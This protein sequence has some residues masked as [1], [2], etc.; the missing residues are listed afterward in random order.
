MSNGRV[1]GPDGTCV[2]ISRPHHPPPP[3]DSNQPPKQQQARG[4]AVADSVAK[5]GKKGRNNPSERAAT[6]SNA[7]NII[8]RVNLRDLTLTKWNLMQLSTAY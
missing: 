4:E 7:V 5:K 8:R 3:Q 6:A 2:E 1:G